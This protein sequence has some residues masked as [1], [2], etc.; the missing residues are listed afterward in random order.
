MNGPIMLEDC[1]P[2]GSQ[3]IECN[4]FFEID[5]LT[6]LASDPLTPN[7]MA[8]YD[9]CSYKVYKLNT[10]WLVN[11]LESEALATLTNITR[12]HLLTKA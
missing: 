10:Q 1:T 6:T 4:W 7:A 2:N 11:G 8:G 9:R 5:V 12:V 3:V